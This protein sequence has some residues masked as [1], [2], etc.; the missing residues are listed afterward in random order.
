MRASLCATGNVT[1][2]GNIV[3]GIGGT[4]LFIIALAAFLL[5]G[6]D[7]MP[8]MI[9]TANRFWKEFQKTRDNVEALVRAEV[10]SVDPDGDLFGMKAEPIAGV[11]PVTPT[12]AAASAAGYQEDEEDEEEE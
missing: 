2:E 1:G 6:P 8:E 9:K 10:S 12:V 4:E 3:F 5:F 11:P 7:K